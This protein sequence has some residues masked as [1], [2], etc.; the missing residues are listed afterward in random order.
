LGLELGSF[1]RDWASETVLERIERDVRSGIASGEVHGTPTL[2]ID[3]ALY[4]GPLD[5]D[6]LEKALAR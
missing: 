3:G 4:L 2:F 6:E 1:E 5:A